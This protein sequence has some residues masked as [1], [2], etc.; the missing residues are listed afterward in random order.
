MAIL[1]KIFRN[2]TKTD[3]LW[4]NYRGNFTDNLRCFIYLILGNLEKNLSRRREEEGRWFV[5]FAYS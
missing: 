5:E 1:T 2:L 3:E 4:Q